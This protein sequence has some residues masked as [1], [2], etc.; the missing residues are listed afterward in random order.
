[1][2]VTLKHKNI[3]VTGATSG[4]GRLLVEQLAS[5]GCNLDFCGRS[6]QK[7][8][9][10]VMSVANLSLTGEKHYHQAF[11]LSDYDAIASFVSNATAQL[12]HIDIL[13]NCA[14][15]NTSRDSVVNMDINDLQQMLTINMLAPCVFM[16]QVYKQSMK[17]QQKGMVINVMSTVC[18]FAN[19]GIAGYTAAKS[20]WDGLTKVFRKEVRNEGI[21][22]CAIYPG[23]VDTPFRE[24]AR[25]EYL[26]PISVVEAI[27]YMASQTGNV[28]VDELVVRPMVEK[29]YP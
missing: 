20:G 12:G 14:G 17:T 3:L 13:I 25:P 2:S 8:Q 21:K 16:Q 9:D 22:V 1:M 23:G 5:L 19:E 18:S 10:V 24:S 26:D 6:S 15:A 27:I 29:N 4:I 28:C 7:M 11:E